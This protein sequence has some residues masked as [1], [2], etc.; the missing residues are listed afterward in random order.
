MKNLL[1]N[2]LLLL[3]VFLFWLKTEIVY[4]MEFN[5][6]VEGAFQI[7]L[8]LINPIAMALIIFSLV[9]LIPNRK[10]RTTIAIIVYF[11]LSMLLYANVLYYREFSDF[12]SV[13]LMTNVGNVSEGLNG[14]AFALLKWHDILYWLDFV[15]ITFALIKYGKPYAEKRRA[16]KFQLIPVVLGLGM[17]LLNITL[18]EIDRPQL[19]TRTFDQRYLVKYLGVNTFTAYDGVKHM[20][21]QQKRVQAESSDTA[22]AENFVNTNR[23]STDNEYFGV[24]KK[25]NVVY[26]HLESIQQ[27]LINYKLDGEEVTPFLNQLYNS[28]NSFSFSNFYHQTG[29]G[30]SSD[31]ENLIENSLFGLPQGSAFSTYGGTNEFQ[32]GPAILKNEQGY[33][34]AAFH[35]N[36]GSFWN[37]NNAY[38]RFGYDYFFDSSY[39]DLT[40]ANSTDYGLKDKPFYEQ[41]MEMLKQLPQ[42]FQTKFI[43]VSN[44]FPYPVFEEDVEFANPGTKD[45]TINNYFSTAHYADE[46]IKEFF[47]ALKKEGLYE[48]TIFVLYGDH[49]GISKSRL[50]TLAPLL[51][52]EELTEFDKAQLQRVPFII[53]A[54]G[55]KGKEITTQAGQIDVQPTVQH[56]LGIDGSKYLQLG[57][58]LLSD[59]PT[60]TV[61][62]RNGDVI[63]SEFAQIGSTVYLTQTGEPVEELTNE[64]NSRVTER[65]HYAETALRISDDIMQ[66]DLLR[67]YEP[68]EDFKIPNPAKVDYKVS[69]SDIK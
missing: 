43:T 6:G 48:N 51:G 26:L 64:E 63:T 52:K 29:Q 50:D 47:D 55:I 69:T 18:A 62:F 5:L 20:K 15:F 1:S 13:N 8:L 14:S 4:F 16:F 66:R 54:P 28:E 60:D 56:L 37:R 25:R 30:K 19:L 7:F 38:K 10:L 68:S 53:H 2:R 24:A 17:L 32:A 49:Y 58:S 65:K 11:A 59:K 23:T 41:S 3:T 9:F 46:A 12:L 22:E 39:Y 27:F 61:V 36:I 57:N 35:G 40:K 34:S 42:P 67:F 44:H 31:A 45:E 33:T 21:T